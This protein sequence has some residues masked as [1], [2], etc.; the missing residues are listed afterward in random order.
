[1]FNPTAINELLSE[2][3]MAMRKLEPH[4]QFTY[5]EVYMTINY[6]FKR[7]A[8][9]AHTES[10]YLHSCIV[11]S[12]Q[13]IT[14]ALGGA[15]QSYGLLCR[16]REGVADIIAD[17]FRCEVISAEEDAERNPALTSGNV[18]NNVLWGWLTNMLTLLLADINSVI[19]GR[20]E[21]FQLQPMVVKP[22]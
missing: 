2:I 21:P 11:G 7:L 9:F 1:M 16:D 22:G 4:R 14:D 17:T 5:T 18:Y 6:Q 20:T 3:A 13:A 10:P 15:R 19:A 12:T 8:F